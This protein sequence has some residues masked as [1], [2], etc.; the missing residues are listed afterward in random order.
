MK[1]LDHYVGIPVCL[2]LDFYQL[3][4]L[5]FTSDK[6]RRI[7]R[8]LVMKYFGIGSILL[9]SPMLRAIK[10]RYPDV[11]IGFLTFASNHEMV[12]RLGLV[13]VIYTLRTDSF[14]HFAKD[15]F[16]IL[17][18]IRGENY[19]ATIDMEFFAKFST[20]VT[21]LAKSPVRI[22]YYLRQMWRGNLLTEEIYYNHYKH[23]SEVFAALATPLGV[24]TT[25]YNLQQ[26]FLSND[27]KNAANDML[28]RQ[29]I[30]HDELLIGFNI[31]AS[32]LSYERRWSQEK[33]LTLA[34][35]LLKEL[36]L[37]LV[38]IGSANDAAYVADT[39]AR[40]PNDGRVINLAGKTNL[41]ELLVTLK[42]CRLFITNDS[43]PLHLATALGVPIISFFGPE[44][45][46]LYGPKVVDG[47]VFYEGLYC[48]PCLNVFNVKTAPCKGQNLCM[49]K[50]QADRV[51]PEMRQHFADIWKEYKRAA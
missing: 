38:F 25:D 47:M 37:R 40:L 18:R 20:I 35:S 33:F 28:A 41:A 8:I 6:K 49:Q 48:S 32:D 4:R 42:H 11:S 34:Q 17:R 1:A 21:F 46:I 45:P 9:A 16:I 31:N 3:L 50:I 7:R 23:I 36:N 44:T 30:E 5:T 10:A 26:P 39:I 43:G 19:D 15:L 27:E 2:L 24:T 14:T 13:D 12:Q 29:G 51:L 22:G